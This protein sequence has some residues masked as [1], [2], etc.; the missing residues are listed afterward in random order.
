MTLGSEEI[1]PWL[2]TFGTGPRAVTGT[3]IEGRAPVGPEEVLVHPG[4]SGA[5]GST[6]VRACRSRTGRTRKGTTR[7]H[8]QR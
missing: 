1:Q 7:C 2:V 4:Y 5:W 6:S 8:P 3:V